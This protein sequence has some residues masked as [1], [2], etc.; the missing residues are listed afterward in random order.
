MASARNGSP[1]DVCVVGAGYAGLSAARAIARADKDVVVLEA[2]SRVGG[3]IWSVERNGHRVDVGGAFFGPEQDVIRAL[4]REYGVELHPTYARGEHTIAIGADVRRYRGLVPRLSP[5]ALLGLS[6]GLARLDAAARRVPVEEPWTARRATVWDAR[7][8]GEW[9]ARTAPAGVGRDL[10]DA[11]VRGLMTCDPREVSLLHLLQLVKSAGSIQKLLAI[12][13]G[14]QQDLAVGGA[15]LIAERMAAELGD[16][17]VLGEPVLAITQDDAQVR[18]T[19]AAREVRTRCVIV[20]APPALAERIAFTP[21][22][23]L[24]RVQLLERMLTGSITKFVVMYDSPFWRADGASGQSVGRPFA[25]RDDHR[26]RAARWWAG[27]LRGVRLRPLLDPARGAGPA[28]RRALLVD[29]LVTRFGNRA[30]DPTDVV[31]QNWETEEWSHGC[32]MAH[33]P[34]GALTQFGRALTRAV[35]PNPLGGDGDGDRWSRHDG[36]RRAFGPARRL[37]SARRPLT[38]TTVGREVVAWRPLSCQQAR[39]R[40]GPGV[41]GAPYASSV[42]LEVI[43]T[44]YG[45]PASEALHRVVA[46]AKEADALAPVTVIVP[47]NSVGV[48]ARRRLAGEELGPLRESGRGIVGVTF[49]TVYRL[50]E[51]LAAPALAT[52]RR[53]PVSTPVVASAVRRALDRA[54]GLFAP[55]A[56]H[57]ATQEALVAAHRELADLDDA[58]L[59]VLA[60]QSAR[61]RDVVRLHRDTRRL[62]APDWYDEHD[63]L[64][65]ATHLVADRHPL[66]DELGAIVLFLPAQWSVPA[67][68]FVE[69]LGASTTMTIIAACTGVPEADAALATSLVRIGAPLDEAAAAQ[70]GP[71]L[72]TA[73]LDASDPDDEV[74]AV[75]RGVVDG[76]REGVPLEK[77]AVLYGAPEPYARLVHEH[78]QLAGIAHNGASVRTLTDSVLGRALLRLLALPDGQYARDDVCG[79]FGTAPV[80]DGRG[81]PVDS[82]A[83]ER[84]SR[85]AGVVRGL[86]EWRDRLGGYAASLGR[87]DWDDR[88]RARVERLGAFVETVANE[89][90]A[91]RAM[92]SWSPLAKWAHACVRRFFGEEARRAAWPAFEREAALRVEAAIDRLATLDTVEPTTF[93]IFRRT[94]ALELD[95]AR[96][97]VGRLGEGLLAGPAQL[98]LG[99]ELERVWVLGLAE[100]IFPSVPHDDPLLADHERAALGGAL[101]LRAERVNDDH[102]ALLAALA[103]TRGARVCTWPR[104]DLRRSTEYVPS[105]F[106]EPTRAT[107]EDTAQHSIAS[108]AQGVTRVAFPAT[109]HELAVQAAVDQQAWVRALVP[110]SL[111]MELVAAR[112]STAFT[113]FDGNLGSLGERLRV[114]SPAAGSAPISPTRLER[115]A[116]CPYAYF[117]ESVLHVRP[118]ERP[119]TIFRL[120]PLDRGSLVHDVLDA[121]LAE[122]AAEHDPNVPWSLDE[123]ARLRSIALDECATVEARG[124]TGRRLLWERD[125]RLIFAELDAFLDADEHYRADTGART[126]ATELAFGLPGASLDALTFALIDGRTLRLRGKADRVDELPLGALLVIDY[127]TGSPYPYKALGAENPVNAGQ[128]LQLPV[129]AYAA[130]AAFGTSA[131]PVEARYWFVGRGENAQIGYVVDAAVDEA[132]EVALRTIVDGIETGVFVAVPAEPGPRPFVPCDACDPDGLGTADRRR[133]FDRKYAAPEL[134]VYRALAAR[135]ADD[136]DDAA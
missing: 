74:R 99:V 7:S 32:S 76:M 55:V 93:E 6:L 20:A 37:R 17:I 64:T 121:F 30:A 117:I 106:L 12:E 113:R 110:V 53:R 63:L 9:V 120:S 14:Y 18:V 86:D 119:E 51:M 28:R 115:W 24:D 11:S 1:V 126:R 61:A 52:E 48:G 77:M 62:L 123:R 45:R 82:V 105:R 71:A 103:C 27:H 33:L 100:G 114:I 95:A 112:A 31:E 98:V 26:R 47:T 68:R 2:R 92:T 133:E 116:R 29:A 8:A 22:L 73:V 49:V 102:R 38:L 97:R 65:R 35:R 42:G 90:E 130:R 16:R 40:V 36:R 96:D 132:F 43:V 39:G 108:Y 118:V 129:Y 124:V 79:F 72:G 84:T 80:L 88:E 44:P 125:R 127:K 13:G 128:N 136:D 78:L 101:R 21:K 87:D 134:E 94:L 111:G 91:A 104:G 135:G 85:K 83:W 70:I 5:V 109:E 75:V 23:P 54:P 25:D 59:A 81:K 107:L 4:A 60:Q 10:L 41:A 34:P 3:R 89:L 56:D 15:S 58:D 131:T 122:R 67:A 50:A 66:V 19:T 57:P 69:A 46:A